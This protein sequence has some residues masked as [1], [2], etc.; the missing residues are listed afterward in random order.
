MVK[1]RP[2]PARMKSNNKNC[3]SE[4]QVPAL[5]AGGLGVR[6]RTGVGPTTYLQV[7]HERGF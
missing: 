3:R 6:S 2:P 7:K 4:G 1:T 5:I